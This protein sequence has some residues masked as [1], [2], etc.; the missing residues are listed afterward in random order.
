MEVMSDL[1]EEG[2][3]ELSRDVKGERDDSGGAD[4]G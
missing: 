4:I 2:L 1:V 3:G